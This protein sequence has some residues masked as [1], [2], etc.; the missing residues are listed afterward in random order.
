MG[1]KKTGGL[2]A[3]K[4]KKDFAEIEKEAE[5]ADQ[6]KYQ[7][8]EDRKVDEAKRIEDESKA[9]ANMR[10]A[11]QDL[12]LQQKKQ[13]SLLTN[14]VHYCKSLNVKLGTSCL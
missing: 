6:M 7:I 1:A 4:V 14:F 9:A 5:M 10:L 3:Q 8:E 12:S 11:Y 2:G 13:V